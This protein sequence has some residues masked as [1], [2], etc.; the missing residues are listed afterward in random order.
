MM[1]NLSISIAS[2]A[3]IALA[4]TALTAQ[5]QNYA[6]PVK[7]VLVGK[8]EVLRFVEHPYN[9]SQMLGGTDHGD[10]LPDSFNVALE[11]SMK[12]IDAPAQQAMVQI[13]LRCMQR[14]TD[15]KLSSLN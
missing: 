14:M 4:M 9:C 5:A 7:P 2:I 15:L 1:K 6:E 11:A 3:S 10:M 13:K 8:S 12:E